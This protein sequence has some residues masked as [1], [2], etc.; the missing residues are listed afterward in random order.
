MI[1]LRI[2]GSKKD[3]RSGWAH[4]VPDVPHGVVSRAVRL[5]HAITHVASSAL[6]ASTEQPE[7]ECEHWDAIRETGGRKA[8]DFFFIIPTAVVHA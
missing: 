5:P 8:Q 1:E 7:G 2:R 4:L 6:F 3:D